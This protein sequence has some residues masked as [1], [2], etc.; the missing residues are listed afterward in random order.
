MMALYY[1]SYG[2]A[3]K[4]NAFKTEEEIQYDI[5]KMGMTVGQATIAYSGLVDVQLGNDQVGQRIVITFTA[6]A[7]NFYDREMIY[8]DPETYYPVTITRDLNLWGKKERITESYDQKKGYV[9]VTKVAQGKQTEKVI[10]KKEMLDNIYGFIYRY[11]REGTFEKG[12]TLKLNLP[13]KDVAI[14]LVKTVEVEAADQTF[15]AYYME[16]VPKQ[17]RIWFDQSSQKV[18]L[19]ID[20]AVG[21]GKTSLVLKGYSHTDGFTIL[22]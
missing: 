20:G 16:S 18:P 21:F 4:P 13:T 9:K 15:E 10:E 17:Y 7:M 12:Q 5:K 6:K 1:A 11:R 2:E 8:L 14:L 3:T 22:D 19:R